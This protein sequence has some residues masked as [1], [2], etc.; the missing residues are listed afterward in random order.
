MDDCSGYGRPDGEEREAPVRSD[1]DGAVRVVD[2]GVGG[3]VKEGQTSPRRGRGEATV[4]L[5]EP[6]FPPQP[7][8]VPRTARV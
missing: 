4:T 3:G 8:F 6:P 5:E 7:A 1:V 2:V